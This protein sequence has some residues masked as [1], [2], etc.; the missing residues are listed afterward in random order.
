MTISQ[1]A[2]A[3]APAVSRAVQCGGSHG[4]FASSV[5]V[6]EVTWLA[7]ACQNLRHIRGGNLLNC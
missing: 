5:A 7:S 3:I 6:I 4:A 1:L 2:T